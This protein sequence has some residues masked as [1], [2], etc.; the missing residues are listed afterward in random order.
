MYNLSLL[1]SNASDRFVVLVL[2]VERQYVKVG[3]IEHVRF[4]YMF[5]CAPSYHRI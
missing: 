4:M 2:D 3:G 1:A 5:K